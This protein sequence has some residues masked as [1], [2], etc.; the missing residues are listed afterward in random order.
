MRNGRANSTKTL[1]D[2]FYYPI[3]CLGFIL[4]IEKP[5]HAIRTESVTLYKLSKQISG[6]FGNREDDERY[7][8]MFIGAQV[9]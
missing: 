2:V 6:K 7:D 1:S 8:T 5:S 9:E 3:F 4:F